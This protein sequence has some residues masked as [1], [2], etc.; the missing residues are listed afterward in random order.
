[1]KWGIKSDMLNVW[2]VQVEQEVEDRA[3]WF[4]NTSQ[5]HL[6]GRNKQ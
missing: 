3:E 6:S 5:V 1:M 2:I 4:T